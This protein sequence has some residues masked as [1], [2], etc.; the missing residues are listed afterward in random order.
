MKLEDRLHQ[1]NITSKAK[2]LQSLWPMI[3]AKLAEGVPHA[4]ILRLLNELG[5]ELTER[6]YKSCLYRYRK[7][8]RVREVPERAPRQLTEPTK[9]H[10][11][12]AARA[13]ASPVLAEVE[14]H[15]RPA[16]FDYDPHGISPEL[17][18]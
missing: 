14:R 10:S 4:E 9:S 2:R 3:E 1:L 6:T 11:T 16:T 18:K 7:R 12:D 8:R 13:S 15:M 17:L 5:F